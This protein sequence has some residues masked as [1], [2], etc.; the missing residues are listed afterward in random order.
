MEPSKVP[1]SVSLFPVDTLK[2]ILSDFSKYGRVLRPSLGIAPLS[3]G[4]DLAEQIGL[5][6]DS[7][8]LIQRVLP[9]GAAQR[10]GSA[11][12]HPAGLPGEHAHLSGG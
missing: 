1:A 8:V 4:P 6:A 11:R 5:P 3:I 2:A 7:G 12:R 10:A 9:G